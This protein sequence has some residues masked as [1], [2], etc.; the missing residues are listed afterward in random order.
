MARAIENQTPW[1]GADRSGS[2]D[3]G[4]YD[5][6]AEI[7]DAMGK[8]V[9]QPSPG[10]P[11]ATLYAVFSKNQLNRY[12]GKLPVG[13]DADS[14]SIIPKSPLSAPRTDMLE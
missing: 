5:G 13:A 2:D 7:V 4:N 12:R 6:L 11:G 1:V 8:T 9:A 14:F 3:Y 10:N